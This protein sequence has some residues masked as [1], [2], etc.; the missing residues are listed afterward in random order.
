MMKKLWGTLVALMLAVPSSQAQEVRLDIDAQK[1]M[2]FA[3]SVLEYDC[4]DTPLPPFVL[5]DLSAMNAVGTY[6]GGVIYID[7]Y[8]LAMGSKEFAETIIVHELTHYLDSKF[9]IGEPPYSSKAV[10]CGTEANAYRVSNAYDHFIGHSELG[11][12]DWQLWY[13]C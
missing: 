12:Y 7:P 5:A 11:R 4:K 6:F 13:G 3:C 2:S 1:L 10:L 9:A 8:Q